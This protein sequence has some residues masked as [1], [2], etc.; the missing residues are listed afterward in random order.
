M[1]P[2]SPIIRFQG[3]KAGGLGG[4]VQQITRQPI[5][6]AFLLENVLGNRIKLHPPKSHF[7]ILCGQYEF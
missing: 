6:G 5:H 1:S 2:R 4:D 3:T 7:A